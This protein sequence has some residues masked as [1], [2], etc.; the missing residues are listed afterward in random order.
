MG[1]S[2]WLETATTVLDTLEPALFGENV[3]ILGKPTIATPV[4]RK[5]TRRA[6]SDTMSDVEV[7]GSPVKR[8]R[9]S[10]GSV[11][12]DSG[13]AKPSTKTR[14][15]TSA[16]SNH[17]A[18]SLS[19]SNGGIDGEGRTSA[20][21]EGHSIAAS[22]VTMDSALSSVSSASSASSLSP[23]QSSSGLS[24]HVSQ[25]DVNH[26]G[27]LTKSRPTN[28]LQITALGD[29]VMKL[30]VAGK[31]QKAREKTRVNDIHMN[32]DNQIL[33]LSQSSMDMD[34]AE[35]M[36]H[37]REASEPLAN[38]TTIALEDAF[39]V[40]LQ[41]ISPDPNFNDNTAIHI[42]IQQWALSQ[43]PGVGQTPAHLI[44]C[45]DR[46]IAQLKVLVPAILANLGSENRQQSAAGLHGEQLREFY[47]AV[48]EMAAIGEW[49]RQRQFRLLA[50]V[51][52]ELHR[53][54]PQL[55]AVIHMARVS[56]DMYGL[57]QGAT[58]QFS[59]GLC[60]MANEYE[61]LIYSK[62]SLYGDTLCQG[63]LS[64]KAMGI[65][66][67]AALLMRV[68]QYLAAITEQCLTRVARTYERRARSASAY[69]REEISTDQL[70]L[71][72]HQVLHATTLCVSLCGNGFI[73]YA[74]QVM[75]IV[76]ESSSWAASKFLGNSS[77][78][79]ATYPAHVRGK[80]LESRALRQVRTGESLL[81]LLAYSRAIL[82]TDGLPLDTTTAASCQT[83][84]S[85]LVDLSWSLAQTLS[86]IRVE[87]KMTNPSSVFLLFAELVV[88]FSKRV[89]DCSGHATSQLPFLLSRLHK[90]H[91]FVRS[92]DP[93]NA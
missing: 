54:L 14:K 92:L 27:P 53:S 49:L 6:N 19:V 7:P 38:N 21:Y 67:D 62:R 74:P 91:S 80:Q 44:E 68:R 52:P 31:S 39:S 32:G 69:G 82:T 71:V 57:V 73:E 4:S 24:M 79:G 45:L 20:V 9:E 63:G 65:P 2:L 28:G 8:R 75:Y 60:E 30:P 12:T 56:E 61:E 37:H 47:H 55:K 25:S 78:T 85:S 13:L 16:L 3:S 66:V 81:K 59:T 70:L 76:A 48:N 64:W 84:A 5:H 93:Y 33:G 51:F 41:P 50:V 15:I 10:V 89:V 11:S 87:G 22:T 43:A 17:F 90:M 88:K 46:R 35:I 1:D 34:I 58:E 42:A 26:E 40:L 23:W 18:R 86:G 29:R 77:A 72:S 36:L 83:L